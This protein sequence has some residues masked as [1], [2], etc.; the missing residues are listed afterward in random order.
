LAEDVTVMRTSA[1][2]PLSVCLSNS[3]EI[4]SQVQERRARFPAETTL[5]G[6]ACFA[7]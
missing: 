5:A 1:L 4:D 6:A 2:S 3:L 7:G